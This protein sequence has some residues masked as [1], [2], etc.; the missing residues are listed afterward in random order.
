M[1]GAFSKLQDK[2]KL[3]D[4]VNKAVRA[5][6]EAIEV[7]KVDVVNK[8]YKTILQEGDLGNTVQVRKYTEA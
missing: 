3:G 5:V 2:P 4:V 6:E 1:I 8:E 7:A